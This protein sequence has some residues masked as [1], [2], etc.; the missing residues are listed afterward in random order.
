MASLRLTDPYFAPSEPSEAL[1]VLSEVPCDLPEAQNIIPEAQIYLP[2][3]PYHLSHDS[4][5][6]YPLYPR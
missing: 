5:K 3:A 4:L 6:Q 1:G 2:E